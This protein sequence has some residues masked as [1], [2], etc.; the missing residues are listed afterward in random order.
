MSPVR[1][2]VRVERQLEHGVV[3]AGGEQHQGHRRRV[4]GEDRE[5]QAAAGLADAEG[6][7]M[8]GRDVEL[9]T[10]RVASDLM[11]A[12]RA[13]RRSDRLCP[14]SRLS[15]GWFMA[16]LDLGGVVRGCAD[17]VAASSPLMTSSS[18]WRVSGKKSRA[19]PATRTMSE[20]R[21]VMRA[22]SPGSLVP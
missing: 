15:P 19:K 5:V 22:M 7:G 21:L 8:A 6:H 10:E 11:A 17:E 14:G 18:R 2:K 16:P 3:A 1:W 4:A 20:T 12:G 9:A 13:P